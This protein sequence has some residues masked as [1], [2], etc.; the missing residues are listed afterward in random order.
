MTLKRTKRM[1][2]PIGLT[3]LLLLSLLLAACGAPAA[4]TGNEPAAA[5]DSGAPAAA[6]GNLSIMNSGT[7]MP[8]APT[9]KMGRISFTNH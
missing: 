3:L 1:H 2:Q 5:A 8:L 6:K 4:P 7:P 9:I